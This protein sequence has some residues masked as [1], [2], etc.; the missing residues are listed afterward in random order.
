MLFNS[1]VTSHIIAALMDA[2][3]PMLMESISKD[4]FMEPIE[5]IRRN[6]NAKYVCEFIQKRNY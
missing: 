5:F 4:I 2:I 6:S 1:Q 3:E